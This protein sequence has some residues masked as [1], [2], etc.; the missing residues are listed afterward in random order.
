LKVEIITL[1]PEFFNGVFNHSILKRAIDSNAL[2]CIIHD[3]RDYTTDKHHQAD[4]FR[5]GGGAGMLLKPEPLFAVL[6]EIVDNVKPRPL[7]IYPT[8]QGIPFCQDIADELSKQSHIIFICG[9]YKGIDQRVIDRWVDRE[10]SI[11]DY[12]LTGGEI[13]VT[14][15]IDA[16]IRMKPGV[17]GDIDSANTDSF[18]NNCLDCPHFTRPEELD[19]LRVPGVLIS[20]HHLNIETWR[21][22]TSEFLTRRRR[23]DLLKIDSNN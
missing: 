8:P 18:R 16:A 3:L 7:V 23:K 2:E 17:L 22:I 1:F 19:G 11:G 15:I 9:H 20:G 4:D 12:V 6:R 5:F 14:A 21:R 10:Y 13:A